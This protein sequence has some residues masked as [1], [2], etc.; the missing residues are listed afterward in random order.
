MEK[1]ALSCRSEDTTSL[2]P[3]ISITPRI[4]IV[5][6]DEIV[7]ASLKG[8]I[9]MAGYVALTASSGES[10]LE[11][12]ESNFAPLVILDRNMG[13]L[14]GLE[15]CRRIR[16][17]ELSELCLHHHANDFGRRGR[18][19]RRIESGCGR[20]CEQTNIDAAADRKVANG[21]AYLV[22]GACFEAQG[23]RTAK[24]GDDR[25]FDR[26]FQPTLFDETCAAGSA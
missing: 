12:L 4:L 22:I 2:V 19:Y 17:A 11:L 6:G 20:V 13:G 10:A 23:V 25:L 15:V 26:C 7:C 18:C 5:D 3:S 9:E 24:N 8:E 14:D 21:A 16:G 1:T